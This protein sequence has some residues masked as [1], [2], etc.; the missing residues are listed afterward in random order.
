MKKLFLALLCLS[1]FAG[2][3]KQSSV[4][5]AANVADAG[6]STSSLVSYYV[7]ASTGNDTHAGTS[8]ST[9]LKTIQAALNKT[10]EG[11]GA[12]IYVAGGTYPERLEWPHSGAAGAYITL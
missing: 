1:A 9:A 12:N 10:T 4:K 6:K 5:P 8:P 11:V 3:T 7:N 2:C